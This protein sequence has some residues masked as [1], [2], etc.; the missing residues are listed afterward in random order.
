M[1]WVLLLEMK[2]RINEV[3]KVSGCMREMLGGELWWTLNMVVIGVG[4]CSNEPSWDLCSGLWKD[5]RRGWRKFSSHTR[6]EVRDG[7]KVK[8]WCEDMTLKEAF[9]ELYSIAWAKDASVE[10]SLEISSGSNQ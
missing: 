9:L 4:R 5:I 1:A 2:S 6:F 10:A 3:L 7:S 8:F